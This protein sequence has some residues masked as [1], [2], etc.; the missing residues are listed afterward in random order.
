MDEEV[1]KNDTVGNFFNSHFI[2]FKL[3]MDKTRKDNDSLRAWYPLVDSFF[4]KYRIRAYPTFL[5]FSAEGDGIH[6]VVGYR[7]VSALIHVAREAIDPKR[8]YYTLIK[9]YQEDKIDLESIKRLA[10]S[11]QK[12][13][14]D[15]LSSKLA[16]E[17][18]N[19]LSPDKLYTKDNIDFI[20]QFVKLPRA[21]LIAKDYK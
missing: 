6:E 12:N 16:N 4:K 8:Q 10:I 21:Q 3:Q 18:L 20:K 7:N 9:K 17:Y 19:D 13:G 1:Y 2:S 5:F 14:D 15:S 11:A